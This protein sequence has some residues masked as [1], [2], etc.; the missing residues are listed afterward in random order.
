MPT[1]TVTVTRTITEVCTLTVDANTPE[2]A[3]T[4]VE[5][6]RDLG[7]LHDWEYATEPEETITVTP[8]PPAS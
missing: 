8:T 7:E 5:A 4:E 3:Q 1:F 2:Q 6:L